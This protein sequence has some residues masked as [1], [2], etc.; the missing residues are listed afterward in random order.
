[1]NCLYFDV[2]GQAH[3]QTTHGQMSTLVGIFSP[4]SAL[5]LHILMK[6]S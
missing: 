2:I 6:P 5:H 4:I 3:G 1:M